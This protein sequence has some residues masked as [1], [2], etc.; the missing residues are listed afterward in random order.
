M[1]T[2][3]LG[4]TDL[5]LTT[6]GMGTWAIGGPWEYGWGPQND[7]DSIGV[8]LTAIDSGINWIDTAPAYGCGHGEE[9]VGRALRQMSESP[10]IAT[11]CGLTW[12]DK[13]RKV[14]CLDH[15]AILAE[16][17]AC[18]RRLGVDVIDL[19][20][21]HWPV[22]DEQLEEA[23]EAMAKV[24]EQGKV[25]YLGASNFT[26]DQLRRVA[27]ICPPVSLQPPYSMINRKAEFELFDYC[28]ENQ[29]GIVCYSPMQKGLLTGKYTE[30]RVAE[31]APDDHR[32]RDPNFNEK[33]KINLALIEKLCPIA[34]RNDRTLAQ[35]A[36]A[37]VLRRPE[38]TAAI[39]GA[40]NDKQI[41]ETV[42]AGDW[43]LSQED[44]DQIEEL[45]THFH[46]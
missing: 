42:Q 13:R 38:V 32:H 35:L 18:L 37:W 15:N 39:V 36:I 34:L 1:R 4:N 40:R 28:C 23:W 25:R 43:I 10:I 45:L 8:I 5:E 6:I 30:K 44:I 12:D 27:K 20:Q 11:K 22:P 2:R 31:L 33:L 21:L 14:N 41:A 7:D 16:A 9:V 26:V 46:P 17:D 19:W 3:R 29:L 24:L